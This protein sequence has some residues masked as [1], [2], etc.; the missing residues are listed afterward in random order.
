MLYV[1]C[2]GQISPVCL[3]YRGDKN[4]FTAFLKD[5]R[6]GQLQ[7]VWFRKPSEVNNELTPDAFYVVFGKPV[8]Y[9]GTLSILHPEVMPMA[10][11]GEKS[12]LLYAC[13]F[14]YR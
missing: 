5:E 12:N 3:L 8:L 7:L 6:N 14:Y 4:V 13:V 9:R 2:K 10:I 1:Q 11:F